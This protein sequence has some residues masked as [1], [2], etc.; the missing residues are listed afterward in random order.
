MRPLF[1]LKSK[2]IFR[3]DIPE[4]KTF[5]LEKK[6]IF[7][8]F[9]YKKKFKSYFSKRKNYLIS[10]QDNARRMRSLFLFIE[11]NFLGRIIIEINTE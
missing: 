10:D 2:L 11:N 7:S 4:Q 6:N 9:L 1:F 8:R 3:V 5:S